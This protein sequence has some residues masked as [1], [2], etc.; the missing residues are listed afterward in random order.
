VALLLA[1]ETPAKAM[2]RLQPKHKPS[3]VRKKNI[4]ASELLKMQAATENEEME[5]LERKSKFDAIVALV[6]ELQAKWSNPEIHMRSGKTC[7]LKSIKTS[8]KLVD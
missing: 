1:G 8:F 4:R 3:Q 7:S 5:D 2:Q 6:S